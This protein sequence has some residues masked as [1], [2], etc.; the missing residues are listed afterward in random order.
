MNRLRSDVL[1]R[2]TREL[3]TDT[4]EIANL[5]SQVNY[6]MATNKE[7]ASKYRAMLH[8]KVRRGPAGPEGVPGVRGPPG[9]MGPN[10]PTGPRGRRGPRGA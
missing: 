10:G 7:L 2:I 6:A 3:A 5:D 1:D 8:L 9:P 4:V